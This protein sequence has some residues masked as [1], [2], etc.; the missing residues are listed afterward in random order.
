MASEKATG[1]VLRVYE[2]SESSSVVTLFTRE[3]GKISGLAKGAR[4]PKGSFDAALDVLCTCRLVFLRKSGEALDLLTEAKLLR[5]FRLCD[6]NLSRLYAGYYVAELLFELTDEYDAHPPLFDT[7]ER[8]LLQLGNEPHIGLAIVQFEMVALRILGHVPALDRCADCGDVIKQINRI[9]FAHAAGG[10]LC[11]ACR[12][13]HSQIVQVSS[14]VVEALRRI[15]NADDASLANIDIDRRTGGELRGVMNHY[16]TQLLGR[17]P[18]MQK[19]L[20][21]PASHHEQAGKDAT[22]A[23]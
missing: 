4:R 23:T 1:L 20:V 12:A 17:V 16:M 19:Y 3:F 5:R 18:R 13:K 21:A 10:L 11:G 15:A 22:H 7:A 14:Q 8:T 2:F 6:K 9:P